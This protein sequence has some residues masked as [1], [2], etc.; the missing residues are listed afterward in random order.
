MSFVNSRN[1][2]VFVVCVLVACASSG[3]NTTTSDQDIPPAVAK[4]LEAMQ[5]RIDDLESQLNQKTMQSSK[6]D[7]S[8]SEHNLA[9]SAPGAPLPAVGAQESTSPSKRRRRSRNPLHLPISVG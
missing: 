6:G 9:E 7:P 2:L 3:Q 1:L 8:D 4:Q 5:K